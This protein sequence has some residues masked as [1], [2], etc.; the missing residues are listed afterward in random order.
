MD[1]E[2]PI[3]LFIDLNSYFATVE[4]QAN[5]ALRGKP[6]G[7][8]EHSGG[9]ILAPS[10]E[11]KSRGVKTAMPVWEAKKICPEIILV[12]VDPGK[13]RAMTSRFYRIAEDYSNEVEHVSVDEVSIDLTLPSHKASAGKPANLLGAF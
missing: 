11:A 7:V 2:R 12:P 13:I 8:C 5:S 3:F 9:I 1:I 4:Q 6:V 10:R